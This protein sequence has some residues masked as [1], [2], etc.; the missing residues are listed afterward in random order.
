[1]SPSNKRLEKKF[2]ESVIDKKKSMGQV[3]YKSDINL[4]NN[5]ARYV[6]KTNL[7][8]RNSNN[9]TQSRRFYN[10]RSVNPDDF[11]DF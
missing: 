11:E 2:S 7:A 6:K 8:E 9:V 3:L 1:M 10:Q 4:D 5:Q